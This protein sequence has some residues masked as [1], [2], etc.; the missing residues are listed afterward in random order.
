MLLYHAL[1]WFIKYLKM[2]QAKHQ[3]IK[4]LIPIILCQKLLL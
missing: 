1:V 4:V 3:L 2:R